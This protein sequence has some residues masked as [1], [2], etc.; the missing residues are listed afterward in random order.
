MPR[1]KKNQQEEKAK[2]LE[3]EKNKI[4]N[5]EN[6]IKSKNTKKFQD[7]EN[8]DIKKAEEE[9]Q[10]DSE[11]LE[12]LTENPEIETERFENFSEF[13]LSSETEEMP[14]LTLPSSAPFPISSD[15]AISA[16]NETLEQAG[17]KALSMPRAPT[18]DKNTADYTPTTYNEPNYV[19]M[20]SEQSVLRNM[21]ERET[22]VQTINQ[23]RKIAEHPRIKI[24]DFDQ[25]RSMGIDER[26]GKSMANIEQDYISRIGNREEKIELPFEQKKEYKER[27]L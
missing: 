27:K 5:K 26:E 10:L 21:Q 3:R 1:K 20:T 17:E 16:T 11:S 4:H 22:F 19:E 12:A 23:A 14:T 7:I 25:L 15:T 2:K 18:T 9:I 13:M 6:K 24:D 8:S